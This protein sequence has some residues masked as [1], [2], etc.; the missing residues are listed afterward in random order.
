MKKSKTP[1]RDTSVEMAEK[2]LQ[3][4]KDLSLTDKKQRSESDSERTLLLNGLGVDLA[5]SV[6]LKTEF[7]KKGWIMHG[8]F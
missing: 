5:E 8:N 4:L 7:T 2:T 1:L 3:D 6:E